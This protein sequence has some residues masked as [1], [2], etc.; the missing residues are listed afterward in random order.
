M[1]WRVHLLCASIMLILFRAHNILFV[2]SLYCANACKFGVVRMSMSMSSTHWVRFFSFL[3]SN[4]SF[5][6][7]YYLI[8]FW[9][10]CCCWPAGWLLGSPY[11]VFNFFHSH[12]WWNEIEARW[13]GWNGA[14]DKM[15]VN[16]IT[17]VHRNNLPF[18]PNESIVSA[19]VS[20]IF[21]AP[22]TYFIRKK[23]RHRIMHLIRYIVFVTAADV[24][25]IVTTTARLLISYIF[26]FTYFPNEQ[27]K[28]VFLRF[29]FL[30]FIS[31]LL[32]FSFDVICLI[33]VI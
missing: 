13:C 33:S 12:N 25:V 15:L 6:H 1:S 22:L 9:C 8:R 27:T 7:I 14:T 26:L 4:S 18:L 31:A 24:V 2:G 28:I 20:V 17:Y 16:Y 32:D 19:C 3:F 5:L 29:S 23:N 11:L 21:A 30:F 10:Y